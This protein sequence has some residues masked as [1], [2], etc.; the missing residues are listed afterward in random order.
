MG[1][2]G[3]W[4]GVRVGGIRSPRPGGS[5]DQPRGAG[6]SEG[7]CTRSGALHPWRG[8]F[9]PSVAACCTRTAGALHPKRGLPAACRGRSA[10][11]TGAKPP[12]G[13]ANTGAIR[14]RRGCKQAA[15]AF[16][17][18][19]GGNCGQRAIPARQPGRCAAAADP[20][21]RITCERDRYPDTGQRERRGQRAAPG[22]PAGFRIATDPRHRA[23]S[24]AGPLTPASG[25][26]SGGNRQIWPNPQR[27]SRDGTGQQPAAGSN[28]CPALIATESR[29]ARGPLS[30]LSWIPARSTP[31]QPTGTRFTAE[32]ATSGRLARRSPAPAPA[33]PGAGPPDQPRIDPWHRSRSAPTAVENAAS[34]GLCVWPAANR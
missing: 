34:A 24:E 7:R 22:L 4:R 14:P 16:W 31:T 11:A 26:T 27:I 9:R 21:I 6:A 23:A 19:A 1:S 20:G 32:S 30:R 2:F 18:P 10:P 5:W 33:P 13:C 25:T 15:G 3:I 17:R 12:T 28:A 8:C 29:A